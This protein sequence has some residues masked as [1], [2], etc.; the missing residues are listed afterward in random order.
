MKICQ[1]NQNIPKIDLEAAAHILKRMKKHVIDIDGIT[2]QHYI[3]A[4]WE[5]LLHFASQLNCII[6]DVNNGTIDELNIALGLILYKNHKKNKNSDR[7][8]RTISTC[9]VVAKALDLYIRDLYQHQ[10]DAMTATSQ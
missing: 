5:G 10:W 1:N 4:G 2:T 3:N 7:S 6:S 9:P 8:Y